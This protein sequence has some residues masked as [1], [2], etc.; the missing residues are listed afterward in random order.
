MVMMAVLT[1]FATELLV[2][3]AIADLISTLQTSRSIPR[4][5]FRIVHIYTVF[6]RQI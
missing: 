1:L 6:H 5:S 2:R 3:P 4:R